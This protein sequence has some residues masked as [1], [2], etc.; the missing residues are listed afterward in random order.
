MDMLHGISLRHT[1]HVTATRGATWCQHNKTSHKH[2][3]EISRALYIYRFVDTQPVAVCGKIK[4]CDGQLGHV[5]CI[6][7]SSIAVSCIGKIVQISL[8]IGATVLDHLDTLSAHT[9]VQTE[10]TT[11]VRHDSQREK[12]DKCI[13]TGSRVRLYANVAI[14]TGQ[15]SLE[16]GS[17]NR[18]WKHIPAT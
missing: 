17:Q 14:D 13:H 5:K 15:T 3:E 18:I 2:S 10:H 7:G 12:R 16:N 11:A 8:S 4:S 9:Y 6:R 1:G